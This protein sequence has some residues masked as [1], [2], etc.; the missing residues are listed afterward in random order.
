M[1]KGWIKIHRSI[2]DTADFYD[3][4]LCKMACWTDLIMMAEIEPQVR[5][6]K[7]GDLFINRGEVAISIGKLAERWHHSIRH[8]RTIIGWL[9][10][11]E[12]IQVR[13]DKQLTIIKIINYDKYQCTTTS[14][15]V[16]DKVTDKVSDKVSDKVT[17]K[18]DSDVTTNDSTNYNE[19]KLDIDKVTDK[20]SDKVSDKVTDKVSDNIIKNNKEY[21]KNNIKKI[22][23]NVDIK[24]SRIQNEI[25][26]EKLCELW[27]QQMIDNNCTIPQ[28]Q[29]ITDRRK[30]AVLSRL[31]EFGKDDILK[32]IENCARSDFLNGRNNRNFIASF[33]WAFLPNNFIKILE[34]NYNNKIQNNPNFQN[35]LQT[36]LQANTDKYFLRRGIEPKDYD[37]KDYHTTF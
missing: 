20:V 6:S 11:T 34:G 36:G 16:I 37:E 26:F 8:C 31:R 17:D 18:V 10:K 9:I 7:C 32:V 28:I 29:R 13:T 4:P 14:D 23:T 1:N 5:K 2:I 22:S 25:D 21:I 33:D 24:E 30:Q 35:G 27:N 3:E 19:K 12:R 15:K